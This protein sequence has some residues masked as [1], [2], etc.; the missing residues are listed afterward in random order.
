MKRGHIKVSNSGYQRSTWP[1]YPAQRTNVLRVV[2]C[3]Y[4]CSAGC[5]I[6]TL[7]AA[8]TCTD[9][10]SN[11][12]TIG[13]KPDQRIVVGLVSAAWLVELGSEM[14]ADGGPITL[15]R[16]MCCPSMTS[17]R[18]ATDSRSATAAPVIS[19]YHADEIERPYTRQSVSG[20]TTRCSG[21]PAAVMA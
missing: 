2:L 13:V 15:L 20:E 3:L 6:G 11:L 1:A 16:T 17:G 19:K 7:T 5:I 14:T 21:E 4:Q 9:H 8:A 18:A 12:T 10:T